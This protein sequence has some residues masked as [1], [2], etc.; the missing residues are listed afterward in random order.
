[1]FRGSL[2][3]DAQKIFYEIVREWDCTDIFV[4]CSGNFTVE[5]VIDSLKKFNLHGNDV[6]L[7]TTVLGNYFAGKDTDFWLNEIHEEKYGWLKE[8]M[9]DPA[10]KVATILLSTNFAQGVGKEQ[11]YYERIRKANEKQ[12]PQIHAQTK[13]KIENL[14]LRLEDYYCGDVVPYL[15]SVPHDQGVISFPPFEGA[16]KAFA[17]DFAKL[18]ELFSWNPPEYEFI[19]EQGLYDL[20][21]K[22][23][24]HK[25]WM[26]GSNMRLREEYDPYLR[27]MA[28][29]TNRGVPIYIYSGNGKT[30]VATPRQTT[31][32]V[33]IPRL[34]P[35]EDIGEDIRLLPLTHDQF[36]ALRSQYMNHNIRP[37]QAQ[38]PMGVI[39]DN[40]LI[41][42]FA[43]SSPS[44]TANW[45]SKIEGPHIYMLSDFPVAPSD[46]KRLSK[47]VL[48]AALSK[49]S[50]RQAEKMTKRRARALIT[51]AFSKNPVSMKYR[52]IFDVMNRKEN[53]TF[54]EE[55]SKEIDPANSY[56]NQQYEIN[57]GAYFGKWTLAEGL[58]IWKKKHGKRG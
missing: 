33:N 8:Y 57:Y 10:G 46:Y 50:Q 37:G 28:K 4:G 36:S 51:T 3:S 12:F 56:Y 54:E 5:R 21:E 17:R 45:D 40:K 39:V 55:W 58:K 2:P 23:K 25:H 6:T 47:L 49:E 14:S 31:E 26:F 30:R 53:N 19:E 42:V 18:E 7:Y 48:Y 16:A 9:N 35:G 34:T 52:G 11:I 43:L 22:F 24:E 29:T 20:F 38:L 1:M 41:G 27:G 13:E 32:I 15:N 44:A